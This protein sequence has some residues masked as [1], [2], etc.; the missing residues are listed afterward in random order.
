M[1]LRI[2][3]DFISAINDVQLH[4]RQTGGPVVT[5]SWQGIKKP[6]EFFE[7]LNISFSSYIPRG[8]NSWVEQVKPNMPWAEN[9]FYERVYGAPLNPGNEYKY[10]PWYKNNPSNDKFRTAIGDKFSHTYMERMWPK[11]AP[12]DDIEYAKE[13]GVI[14]RGIRYAY[15][16][17][18]DLVKLLYREPFTRQAFLPIWF[19]EDTGANEGQRVPCTLGYH[20]LRRGRN[21]HV[22]YYIRSCDFFR[23]FRDDIYLCLKLVGWII[24]KLQDEKEHPGGNWRLAEPG[25][26]TMHITSLHIFFKEYNLLKDY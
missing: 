21:L 18:M 1:N 10:W 6:V 13:G 7:A 17:L 25:I 26:F 20:F 5:E 23:H 14:N 24:E 12:T 11:Y 8:L 2:H 9:H 22:T 4:L 3:P 16:D 15:G 19:P